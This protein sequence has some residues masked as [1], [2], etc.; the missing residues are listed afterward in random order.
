VTKPPVPVFLSYAHEDEALCD[1]LKAHLS[2]LQHQGS[3]STWHDRLI[4]PGMDWAHEIDTHLETASLILLLV[5]A[6]FFAS[7]YCIGVEMKRALERHAAGEAVVI[8]ILLRPIDWKIAPLTHLQALP[9]DA[10]PVTSWSNVDD[11]WVAVVAGIR[12][13]IEDFPL[14]TASAPKAALPPVWNIPYPQNIFFTGRDEILSRLHT[15]LQ[16][17]HITALS[18]PQAVSGLGGIGKTQIAIEY[19]YRYYRDYEAVL[20][21][22]AESEETLISSYSAIATH[23]HLPEREAQ[24]QNITVQAVKRWFQTHRKWVLLLDNADDLDLLPPFLPSG[25]GGHILLT[26]RARD[27]QRLA[28]RIE[29]ETLSDDQGTLFLLRRAGLLALD[30]SLEQADPNER[31]Q[32]R[33]LVQEM[34][35]LPLALDQ[36][37][38]YLDATGM[39]LEEYQRIYK[40]HRRTLLQ[41]RRSRVSD[42]PLP[43]ATTWSLSFQKVQEKNAAAADLLRF[44][45]YL[46]ADAIPEVIITKGA[47][48]FDSPLKSV[49]ENL[50]LFAQAIESL[51]TYSLLDRD[52]QTQTLSVHR[53]VQA[54][55]R[56]SLGSEEAKAWKRRVVLAVNEA[57]PDVTDVKQWNVCERWLPHAEVCAT[58]IEQE[59]MTLLEAAQLLNN[60]GYYLDDR[61]R[62]RDA[63]PL[64]V[65]ALAIREQQLGPLHSDTAQSLNNLAALYRNQG[66]YADAESLL[67]RALAIREQHLGPLHPDTA[68]SLNN[69]AA[70]YVNQGKYADAESLLVRA[71]AIREQHL[72]PLHPNTAGSLN[73]LALLYVNQG[74]DADAEPLYMRALAIREQHL[75]P[76]HPNTAGSLNNLAGLYVN[77]G[78]YGDAEPLYV[79]ALAIRERQL[80]PLHPD[81]AQSLNNL[82][83]LYGWQGKDTDAEPLLVRALA[84]CERQLGPLH[85]DTAQSLNNLA[86]LYRNQGKDTDA[87]PLYV[88]ALAIYE[89]QLGSQHPSTQII[90]RNY[91]LLLRAMGREDEAKAFENK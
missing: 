7:T 10:K 44:C 57:C 83:A 51:R 77:Q 18:Q 23:L 60:A 72:G 50:F 19:V 34:G 43:V 89:Q 1:Q 74:K 11:A 3:V 8:P 82:A 53:L 17:G 91:A 73:N 22:Y 61:A 40:Q 55:L 84:I 35:G 70:L 38:A 58:W 5:S 16:A 32:A 80:G 47:P 85:P 75:G 41:E 31:M 12:L 13:V 27:M 54:V 88:R 87:E 49:A 79:R 29:V 52:P 24:D 37:G 6:N 4:L 25:P 78:K 14:L 81:T 15:Q 76:L 68:Q 20:W 90:R 33:N 69:L 59:Q 26:T 71:L 86:T 21:A 63:E 48:H 28:Q 36:A 9:T 65:R 42:H 2:L 45:A 39:S 30:A 56:D 46:A 66:K 64:Y 62:Y 67:V